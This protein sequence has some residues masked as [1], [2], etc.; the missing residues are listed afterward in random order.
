LDDASQLIADSGFARRARRLK[1]K[2][3]PMAVTALYT[4]VLALLILALAINVTR[5]RAKLEVGLGD[6][7]NPQCC[8]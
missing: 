6:G 7:G 3:M 1:G 5:H 4:S 8:G 2:F